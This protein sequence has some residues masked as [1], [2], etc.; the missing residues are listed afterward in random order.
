[1]IDCENEI[2]NTVA[3]ALKSEFTGIF[4]SGDTVAALSSFPAAVGSEM[5][6]SIYERG[7]DSS[8]AENYV[9]VM[10]QWDA[11]S[12][13]SGTKKSECRAIMAVIDEEMLKLG[14]VR[15]GNGPMA[16]PSMDA[17]KHR[18]VAR[19]RAVISKDK[20]VYGR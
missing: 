17:T 9:T 15:V 7:I 8:G 4:V 16:L 12:N 10:W 5:D 6:N 2:F 1:M 11:I 20:Y 3:T 14:F 19:Y 13:K 18:I